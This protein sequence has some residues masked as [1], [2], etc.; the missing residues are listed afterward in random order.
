[1]ATTPVTSPE[2]T[3]VG[4]VGRVTGTVAKGTVG[5]VMLPVAGGVEAFYAYP[6]DESE[7]IR[8]GD[9]RGC[10]GL[11]A[12]PDCHRN[13]TLLGGAFMLYQHR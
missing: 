1:M 9:A 11:R 3:M 2:M 4:K 5:E 8:A 7:S 6:A 13:P 12:T 10:Y